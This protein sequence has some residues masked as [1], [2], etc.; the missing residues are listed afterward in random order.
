MILYRMAYQS[1]MKKHQVKNGEYTHTRIGCQLSSPIIYGGTYNIPNEEMNTFYKLYYDYV[2]VNGNK[3]YLTEKQQEKLM[4]IDLDF[5]YEHKINHKMH[6]KNLIDNIIGEY[7]TLIKKYV[8][9]EP[10]IHFPVYVF[11]KPNVNQ[12]EDGSLTKDGIHILIGLQIDYKIQMEIRKE[13]ILKSP[14]IFN[15]IPFINNYES[16]FDDGISKGSSNWQL[17]G[18]RKPNNEAYELTIKYDMVQDPHDGEFCWNEEDVTNYI[19]ENTIQEVS[20]RCDKYP[21]FLSSTMN[22]KFIIKNNIALKSTHEKPTNNYTSIIKTLIDNELLINTCSD[23]TSWVNIGTHFKVLFDDDDSLFVELTNKYGTENKK[24]ECVK[25]FNEYIKPKHDDKQKALNIIKKIAKETNADK[26]NEL[27]KKKSKEIPSCVGGIDW[28]SLSESDFAKMYKNVIYPDTTILF[29]GSNKELEGY[30]FNGYFW[31]SL[32]FH[33]AELHKSHFDTLLD[34]YNEKLVELYNTLDMNDSKH[35][36]YYSKAKSSILDLKTYNTRNH[37]LKIFKTDNYVADIKWNKNPNLFVFNDAVYNLEKG[38]FQITTNKE[39]YINFSCG[40]N[41]NNI[42]SES[43]KQL[44][45]DD[46]ISFFKNIVIEENYEYLMK[47]LSS[48][49]KQENMEELAHFWLGKGRNGKGTIAELM[50]NVIGDYWG[51]L[52]IDYYTQYEKGNDRPN[53]NLY[54]CRN[55]RVL[56]SSEIAENSS[57][58]LGLTF[59]TDKFKKITGNDDIYAREL[60]TK[61]TAYFK[62]GKILIQTNIMPSFP[63]MET[64][65]R[66]RIIVIPFPYTFTHDSSLLKEEPNIYKLK[67]ETLKHKFKNDIYKICMIE[68]LFD[69]YKKYQAEGLKPTKNIK[70][71]TLSYFSSQTLENWIKENCIKKEK[72]NVC[73]EIMKSKYK[74]ETGKT[75]SIKQI[76]TQ[77]TELKYEC[78]RRNLLNYELKITDKEDDN[79]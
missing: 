68:I 15:D 39:D 37:V 14:E 69:Y 11:E 9:I 48:F 66:E 53:Q 32:P 25:W 38:E 45:K 46:I 50:K 10:N 13:I 20:V 78:T 29:T 54:N 70:E 5:R 4:A 1:F 12:L 77:L 42:Y 76:N 63:K 59:I 57:T 31:K 56:N 49:L 27:F 21:K 40:Y 52:N 61:N 17:I 65:L 7:L 67:D 23:H 58:G 75:L 72:S 60:G 8:S 35:K 74:E 2:F 36:M 73:L 16:I 26:Y 3:E 64:S 24:N 19:N 30:E 47:L 55:S 71:H 41:Y 6:D 18:S 44:I 62:A 33:N 51:E 43:E 34:F 79:I 22:E 28:D